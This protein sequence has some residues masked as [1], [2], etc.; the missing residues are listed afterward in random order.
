MS[1]FKTPQSRDKLNF[2]FRYYQANNKL[3][4]KTLAFCIKI[5]GALN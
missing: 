4:L 2:L 1:T 3:G 5:S